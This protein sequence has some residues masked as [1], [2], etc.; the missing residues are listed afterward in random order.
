V[1]CQ[2]GRFSFEV[3]GPSAGFFRFRPSTSTALT[4][5]QRTLSTMPSSVT[6]GESGGCSWGG[7]STHPRES[8]VL[9]IP[10]SCSSPALA[11]DYESSGEKGEDWLGNHNL[12]EYRA[13][14]QRCETEA[15][16]YSRSTAAAAAEEE[17][18]SSSANGAHVLDVPAAA[19]AAAA[20]DDSSA[21][22]LGNHNVGEYRA[23]WQQRGE[24]DTNRHVHPVAAAAAAEEEVRLYSA[25]GPHEAIGAAS[26]RSAAAGDVVVQVR[27]V[28]AHSFS[29]S[30]YHHSGR[31]I[32]VPTLPWRSLS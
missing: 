30:V 22:W 23:A 14:W 13:A 2:T 21:D 9:D 5:A 31:F 32:P 3:F 19:A 16:I 10:C 25:T 17:V 7:R 24:N 11:D 15:D 1:Q 27:D 20:D 4:A 6:S 12:G 8:H 28:R 29:S 18:T 26:A